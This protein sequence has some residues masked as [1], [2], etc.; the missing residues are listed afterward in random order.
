M[1]GGGE[2]CGSAAVPERDLAGRNLLGRMAIAIGDTLNTQN[3]LGLTLSGKPGG[4]LF[5]YSMTTTGSHGCGRGDTPTV[6]VKDSSQL[7]ASDYK[8]VFGVDAPGQVVRLSDG[9]GYPFQ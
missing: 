9:K 5:V 8:I 2:N 7:K 4:A 6:T 1:T 3:R